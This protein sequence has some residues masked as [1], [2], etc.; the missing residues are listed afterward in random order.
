MSDP[1]IAVLAGGLS[2]EREVSLRS[3]SRMSEALGDAGWNV[4]LLDLDD[5]LV[6]RLASEPPD[7]VLLALHG[8]A[9]EDGT[10]QAVLEMLDVPYSGPD[11]SASALVWDKGL[12]KGV[13][14]RGG[15]LTPPWLTITTDAIRDLGARKAFGR[16]ERHIGKAQVVKP[17]QGGGSMG[18]TL[19]DDLSQLGDALRSALSYHSAALVEQHVHGTEVAV[20]IL[21]GEPLPPVEAV[22]KQG[23]YDFAARYTHG[24]TEFFAPARLDDEVLARCQEAAVTAWRLTGCRDIARADLIVDEAGQPWFLEIDTCPGMTETSLFPMAAEAAGLSFRAVCERLV[25]LALERSPA[26]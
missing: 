8:K 11:P 21:A 5:K 25:S 2:F 22:P 12:C 17:S 26:S 20:A 9:G 3:G 13:V 15:V 4:G 19:L 1:R 23:S 10:V 6:D 16:L 7:A 18:V 14:S 24:A